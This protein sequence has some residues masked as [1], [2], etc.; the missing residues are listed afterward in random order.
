MKTAPVFLLDKSF[1][2]SYFIRPSSMCD[3]CCALKADGYVCHWTNVKVKSSYSVGVMRSTHFFVLGSPR[4]DGLRWRE[5]L[6]KTWDAGL[7]K[8]TGTTG[9]CLRDPTT[10]NYKRNLFCFLSVFSP[11]F[12]SDSSITLSLYILYFFFLCFSVSFFCPSSFLFNFCLSL[13]VFMSLLL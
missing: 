13:S 6:Q 1:I 8:R 9:A 7:N 2:R 4:F 5:V 11:F 12:C 3:C 10:V